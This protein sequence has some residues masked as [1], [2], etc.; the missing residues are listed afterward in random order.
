M[1]LGKTLHRHEEGLVSNVIALIS[2]SSYYI[3]NDF[4]F[5]KY[6][7]PYVIAVALTLASSLVVYVV[8]RAVIAFVIVVSG[9]P[10]TS[11]RI[12]KSPKPKLKFWG[13]AELVSKY[14]EAHQ[15]SVNNVMIV[16][17][18]FAYVFLAN[19]MHLNLM[20]WYMQVPLMMVSSAMIFLVLVFLV[21]VFITVTYRQN[22]GGKA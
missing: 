6:P 4:V 12:C 14:I 21:S 19:S 10:V 7:V 2:A 9:A 15:Y 17:S 3:L 18:I 8:L 13:R 20:P 11:Y 16:A 1:T 5:S 22:K